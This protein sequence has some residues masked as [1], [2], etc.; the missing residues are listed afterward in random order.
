MVSMKSEIPSDSSETWRGSVS[1]QFEK[2]NL[3]LMRESGLQ[4]EKLQLKE[5]NGNN[6][7]VSHLSEDDFGTSP[8]GSGN[9]HGVELVR[10]WQRLESFAGLKSIY[11][12]LQRHQNLMQK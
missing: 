3:K 12:L 7:L 8:T 11:R 10:G 2:W 6:P 9:A 1:Y 4:K 5:E